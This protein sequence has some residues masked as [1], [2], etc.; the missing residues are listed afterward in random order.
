MR[1]GRARGGQ[2]RDEIVRDGGWRCRS[3]KVLRERR[4]WQAP[5]PSGQRRPITNPP[6]EDPLCTPGCT[7]RRTN[8]VS[9]K[10]PGHS[11]VTFRRTLTTPEDP[12]PRLLLVFA[13]DIASAISEFR[14]RPHV[15]WSFILRF[16]SHVTTRHHVWQRGTLWPQAMPSYAAGLMDA[17]ITLGKRGC[18]RDTTVARANEEQ[19]QGRPDWP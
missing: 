2:E 5:S 9:G 14:Q 8:P 1:R 19:A 6:A 17:D 12:L 18:L 4:A 10:L 3:V 11:C 7:A 13:R 15:F 16:H